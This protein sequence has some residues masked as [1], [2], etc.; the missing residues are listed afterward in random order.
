MVLYTKSDMIHFHLHKPQKKKNPIK[1]PNIA[2]TNQPFYTGGKKTQ[3]KISS[4]L[5]NQTY[6]FGFFHF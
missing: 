6:L 1:L 3:V 2:Q 5:Q 4:T